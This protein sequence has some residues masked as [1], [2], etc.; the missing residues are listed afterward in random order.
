MPD[1]PF[2]RDLL[3]ALA[4]KHN[5]VDQRIVLIDPTEKTVGP[6]FLLVNSSEDHPY[7]MIASAWVRIDGVTTLVRTEGSYCQDLLTTLA[8]KYKLVDESI[9]LI[10]PTEK[11]VE[12]DFLLVNSSKDHPYS[13]IASAWAKV[14][15]TTVCQFISIGSFVFN[16]VQAVAEEMGK[17]FWQFRVFNPSGEEEVRGHKVTPLVHSTAEQP[18]L[19]WHKPLTF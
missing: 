17:P 14:G 10:D 19:I 5:L 1:G 9:V 7:S 2:C 4:K 13:M 3:T 6:G 8:K 18:Y 15:G 11:I 16:M 12:P